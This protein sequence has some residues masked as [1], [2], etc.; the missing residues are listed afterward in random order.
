[1][2]L[3]SSILPIESTMSFLCWNSEYCCLLLTYSVDTTLQ[4][5]VSD[6]TREEKLNSIL[7]KNTECRSHR[8]C[9]FAT[10]GA[11]QFDDQEFYTH[12]SKLNSVIAEHQDIVYLNLSTHPQRCLWRR[13]NRHFLH[14][15]LFGLWKIIDIKN[16]V[17]SYHI[18]LWNSTWRPTS[19]VVIM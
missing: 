18:V 6:M 16:H 12:R 1:M 15:P 10:M 13:K 4:T 9:V 7:G 11:H 8:H 3:S 5:F 17:I 19:K 2:F 14:M